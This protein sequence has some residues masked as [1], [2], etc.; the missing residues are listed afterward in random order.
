MSSTAVWK[1]FLIAA[2]AVL[3]YGFG[4]ALTA[5]G[6]PTGAT[7]LACVHNYTGAV[8][9]V[10]TEAHCSDGER[11]V[12]WTSF[13]GAALDD[14]YVNED[15]PDSI[16]SAMLVDGTVNADDL[17]ATL[18][19]SIDAQT[20]DGYVRRTIGTSV[21]PGGRHSFSMVCDDAANGEKMISGGV[22]VHNFNSMLH[23]IESYPHDD[24]GWTV[25]VANADTV[26]R[27][28]TFYEICMGP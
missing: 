22:Q 19:A 21:P 17:S 26:S 11:L 13:S 8:R 10:Y 23:M 20:L 4:S 15:Q 18:Q 1:L 28:V 3:A 7:I 6:A 9:I 25:T 12:S 5:R 27:D 2:I 14:V 24:T 16:T